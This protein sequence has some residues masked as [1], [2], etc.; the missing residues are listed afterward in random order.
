M[1]DFTIG[2]VHEVLG[3]SGDPIHASIRYVGHLIL[4]G[5]VWNV[6]NHRSPK[7]VGR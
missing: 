2:E 5:L 6:N 1:G 7:D 3:F 4:Y